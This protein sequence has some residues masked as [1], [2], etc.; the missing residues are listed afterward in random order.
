MPDRDLNGTYQKL[1]TAKLRLR[2]HLLRLGLSEIESIHLANRVASGKFPDGNER[3]LTT[4]PDAVPLLDEIERCRCNYFQVLGVKTI[5]IG[6][7]SDTHGLLRPEAAKALHGVELIIHAGDV[8]QPEILS[9]LKNI[10]PTVSVR[11]NVDH[12]IWAQGLPRTRSVEVGEIR[13]LVIHNL[14]DLGV[15]PAADG[16]A[17]VISGHSHK[18]SIARKNGV[19]FLNPGSAGPKR[20]KLPVTISLVRVTGDRVEAELVKLDV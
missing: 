14:D 9:A 7:I 16:F 10:A 6:V 12:G 20:F 5:L 13:I 11:G 1:L 3:V 2:D 18:P 15:D 4:A 8:N 19:L 17:A